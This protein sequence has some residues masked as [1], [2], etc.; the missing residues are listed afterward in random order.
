MNPELTKQIAERLSALNDDAVAVTNP[1]TAI[2]VTTPL[3]EGVVTINDCQF[4]G[5]IPGHMAMLSAMSGP[6]SMFDASSPFQLRIKG[7][8]LYG[9][10]LVVGDESEA[11]LHGV[12]KYATAM[13]LGPIHHN[14]PLDQSVTIPSA[15]LG[16]GS[17]MADEEIH[18]DE[19]DTEF[20]NSLGLKG[21]EDMTPDKLTEITKKLQDFQ[22]GLRRMQR[23]TPVTMGIAV[24]VKH[25]SP[26][27]RKRKK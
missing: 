15:H 24:R 9:D 6:K 26:K 1:G 27:K 12:L 3:E 7:D 19:V 8:N 25:R 14:L 20:W 16:A 18:P 21:P 13:D 11:A 23:E 2:Q 4:G 17:S 22:R 10:R 5:V